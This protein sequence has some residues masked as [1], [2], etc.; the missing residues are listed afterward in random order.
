MAKVTLIYAYWPAQPFGMTWCDVP[1]ALRDAGLAK[2][3][4]AAGHDVIESILMSNRDHPEELISGFALAGEIAGEV[5]RARQEGEFP[6]IVC[7]SCTLAAVGAVAGIGFGDRLGIV[8]ADAHPDL[9]TPET[10]VT[11]LLDGMALSVA[12][13]RSWRALA[14]AE[15]GLAAPANL[16]RCALYGARSIDPPERD[17]IDSEGVPIIADAGAV[18]L[19]L[20]GTE[21]TYF[22]LDCDVHDADVLHANAVAVR[23]GPRVE[24]VRRMIRE[25][26]RLACLSVA[27]LDPAVANMATAAD[28]VI[29][30]VLAAAES[31]H[32]S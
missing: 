13:G 5:R 12:T 6:V 9:N 26:P 29:G 31:H 22:H 2:R 30:H 21:L 8:W 27:S 24:D 15:A 7:G 11:G 23:G 18:A 1:W 17:L 25:T 14:A 28:I 4:H 3:L 32:R 10:T 19:R 20:Q 16:A